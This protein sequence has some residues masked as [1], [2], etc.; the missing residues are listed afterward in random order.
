LKMMLIT[1]NKGDQSVGSLSVMTRIARR[2]GNES[3]CG[4]KAKQQIAA[5]CWN[6]MIIPIIKTQH[7]D[8]KL[9]MVYSSFD[10]TGCLPLVPILVL[11]CN[12]DI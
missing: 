7:V 3:I 11:A 2:T 10:N 9:H 6:F 4:L 1:Y 5:A 12:D 8:N